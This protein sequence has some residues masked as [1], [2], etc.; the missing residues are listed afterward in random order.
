M[1]LVHF[2]PL[3][4]D[5]PHRPGGKSPVYFG[6]FGTDDFVCAADRE[7]QEAKCHSCAALGETKLAHE[8]RGVGVGKGGVMAGNA[9]GPPGQLRAQLLGKFG[10]IAEIAIVNVSVLRNNRFYPTADSV[11][12][13]ALFDPDRRQQVVDVAWSDIGNCQAANG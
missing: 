4:G 6:P 11:C 12:S 1:I 10:G 5:P 8:L 3:A 2:H 9:L 13:F 7:D